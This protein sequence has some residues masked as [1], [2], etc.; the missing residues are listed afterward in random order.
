[1]RAELKALDLEPDP[2]T[3]PEDPAEFA[4][5]ARVY[6]GPA[7]GP[8]EESFDIT[9][10]SPEWL[11]AACRQVGFYDARHHLVINVDQFDQRE[12]RSWL[13]KRVGNV[14]GETWHEIGTKLARLGAWEFED[15]LE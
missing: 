2:S 12:L 3:L 1:M 7:D 10:C 6:A 14:A 15:Y 9:V 5:L 11:A 13:T 8:G 4:L